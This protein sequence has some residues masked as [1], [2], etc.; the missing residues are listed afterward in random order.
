MAAPAFDLQ[1]DVRHKSTRMARACIAH[2]WVRGD[3]RVTSLEGFS[4]A[5]A[6]NILHSFVSALHV[7]VAQV[8]GLPE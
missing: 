7:E 1:F 4:D 2:A 6:T 8:R 5:I 3:S